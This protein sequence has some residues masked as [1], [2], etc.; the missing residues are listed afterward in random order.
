MKAKEYVQD[1]LPPTLFYLSGTVSVELGGIEG[2]LPSHLIRILEE[3]IEI[4]EL[5]ISDMLQE[6]KDHGDSKEAE[7]LQRPLNKQVKIW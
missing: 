4:D 6:K 1:L 3:Y 7:E 5:L 2:F